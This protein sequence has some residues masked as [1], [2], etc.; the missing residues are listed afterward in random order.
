MLLPAFTVGVYD[1]INPCRFASGLIF[2]IYLSFVGYTQ[3]R[4]FWLGLL[5]V[6]STVTAHF[7]LTLG[8]FDSIL[9]MPI[10]LKA[11]YL[12]Y[13]MIAVVLF[14]LGILNILDWVRYKKYSDTT[15]FWC[16][17]P[18]FLDDPQNGQA[19]TKMK[20]ALLGIQFVLL[21]FVVAVV[22]TLTGSIYPQ[23]EHIFIVH[24]YLMAGGDPRFALSSFFQYSVASTLILTATWLI[25]FLI[26][27]TMRQK[28]KAI[29]YY[30]GIISALFLSVGT[31]LGYFFLS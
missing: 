4:I 31:G 13:W 28:T 16:R 23:R 17:M 25:V 5:F 3:K 22:M 21:A 2:I 24:S 18:A 29:V 19:A 12:F 27:F 15:R 30:K 1:S 9:A 20:R 26:G 7:A 6:V 10:V 14:V 8:L 11:I